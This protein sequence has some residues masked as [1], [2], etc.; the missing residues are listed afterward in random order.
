MAKGRQLNCAVAVGPCTWA[1]RL[2]HA[3][4]GVSSSV[5]SC[6]RSVGLADDWSPDIW[7]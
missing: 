4:L 1:A 3:R 5:E 6:S 7:L 2:L